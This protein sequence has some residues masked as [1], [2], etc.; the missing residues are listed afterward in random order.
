MDSS[1]KSGGFGADAIG[2]V[3]GHADHKGVI[4]QGEGLNRGESSAA[5]GSK[6]GRV[7]AIETFKERVGALR[8][9]KR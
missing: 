6:N 2:K 5:F 1:G 3:L 8:A 4:E 9:M 7:G